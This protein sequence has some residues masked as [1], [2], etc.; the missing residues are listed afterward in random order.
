ML[1][2]SGIFSEVVFRRLSSA[3]VQPLHN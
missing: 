1:Y 2:I 3:I